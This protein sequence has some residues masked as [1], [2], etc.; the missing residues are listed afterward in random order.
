[1]CV[2]TNVAKLTSFEFA[3]KSLFSLDSKLILNF[4]NDETFYALFLDRYVMFF[5]DNL[6]NLW[7]LDGLS[8][9]FRRIHNQTIC[10]QI[11]LQMSESVG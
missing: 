8:V 4:D 11:R 7:P 5:V 2:A 9:L 3:T 6:T 1:V 10:C